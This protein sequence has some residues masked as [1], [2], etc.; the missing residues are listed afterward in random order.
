MSK[1]FEQGL[2]AE[3]RRSVRSV[4]PGLRRVGGTRDIEV[5]PF[6]IFGNKFPQEQGGENSPGAFS[7]IGKVRIM[8]FEFFEVFVFKRHLPELFASGV[9]CLKDLFRQFVIVG[10]KSRDAGSDRK[11]VV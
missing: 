7:H 6:D 3:S 9:A 8:V 11:S 2:H 1:H 4:F 5:R 10:E